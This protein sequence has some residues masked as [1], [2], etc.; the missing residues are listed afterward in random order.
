MTVQVDAVPIIESVAGLHP[1]T[2]RLLH[3][4]QVLRLFH[5]FLDAST[6][7]SGAPARGHGGG[8]VA[9]A[10]AHL[11][12]F[13]AAGAAM[14]FWYVRQYSGSASVRCSTQSRM[15]QDVGE[16]LK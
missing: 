8:G 14:D 15:L 16:G 5:C 10:E 11:G 6:S 13:F 12:P 2:Q 9:E 7:P 4:Q 1:D 3:P